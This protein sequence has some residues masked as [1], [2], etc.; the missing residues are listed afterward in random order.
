MA[1]VTSGNVTFTTPTN[2][3]VSERK[4]LPGKE[5]FI[6]MPYFVNPGA[7]KEIG[8]PLNTCIATFPSATTP[9]V[10]IIAPGNYELTQT[11]IKPQW[12]QIEGNNAVISVSSL[13]TPVI[14]CATTQR[15]F[16][17]IVGTYAGRGHR[18]FDVD[19][20]RS[21]LDALWNLA[22]RGSNR[23]NNFPRGAG[24]HGSLR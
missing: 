17:T 15:L 3:T 5:Q 9:G 18:E 14:I 10:C 4:H 2:Q 13:S 6:G 22:R 1:A 7:S 20:Q 11:V 16:P 24:L 23:N 8:G 12:V 21:W 19:G